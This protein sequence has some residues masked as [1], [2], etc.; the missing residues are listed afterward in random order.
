AVP[1]PRAGAHPLHLAAPDYAA[2]PERVAMPELA[3]E[4]IRHDLHV[5]VRMDRKASARRD[6]ILVDHAERAVLRIRRIDVARE[7]E[8]IPR[9]QP[10]EVAIPTLVARPQLERRVARTVRAHHA[11]GVTRRAPR[12]HGR[13]ARAHHRNEPPPIHAPTLSH[14]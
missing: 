14:A 1:D 6:A 4:E 3:L 5:A 10:A 8:R 11:R 12:D 2:M 9:L 13:R 7:R